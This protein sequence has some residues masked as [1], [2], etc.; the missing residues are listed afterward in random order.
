MLR[1][2][3]C[4]F[5]CFLNIMQINSVVIRKTDEALRMANQISKQSGAE[6]EALLIYFVSQGFGLDGLKN[7]VFHSNILVSIN[8]FHHSYDNIFFL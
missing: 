4:N 1:I 5:F 7:N 6:F 2:L 8:D 3:A